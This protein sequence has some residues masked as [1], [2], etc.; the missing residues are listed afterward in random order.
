MTPGAFG[1]MLVNTLLPLLALW[2]LMVPQRASRLEWGAKVAMIVAYLFAVALA[3]V[4]LVPSVYAPRAY[5]ALLPLAVVLSWLTV[6][7]RPVALPTTGAKARCAL[8]LAFA[9]AFVAIG[10]YG[11]AGRAA[12]AAD[13]VALEFPLRDGRF[14][15]ASGGANRAV[16]Y[17]FD[18]PARYRGQ[19][20]G[21]DIVAFDHLGQR[22][23]GITPKDPGD[24]TIFGMPV[25]A[26]CDGT[27]KRAV[28][29]L[30]DRVPPDADREHPAGNHVV[31]ACGDAEVVLA[32][33]RDGS[34]EV[35]EG[36]EIRRGQRIAAVGNSGNTSEPHLHI[37]AQR[38]GGDGDPLL[39]R[40]P[41]A[42]TFNGRTLARGI[43]N[44]ERE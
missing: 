44:P 21:L 8:Y 38:A 40:E 15:V 31:L 27:V 2:W 25:Y 7:K 35:K 4:W 13:A 14:Y 23:A 36:A 33:L 42:M 1:L 19:S 34:V 32:H 5:F 22:A 26:P 20:L 17:H 24:Y 6:R 28:D 3:S 37:H 9:V 11:W 16:N 43:V 39:D 10:L 18:A 30:P 41:L 12:P 29:G